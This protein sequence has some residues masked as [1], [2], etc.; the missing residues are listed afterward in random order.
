MRA[1]F[2]ECLEFGNGVL[3]VELLNRAQESHDS[4][5]E[6]QQPDDQP[7][8]LMMRAGEKEPSADDYTCEAAKGQSE[9]H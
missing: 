1:D 9:D 2:G 8:R 3:R 4:K 5:Y 7:C 6:Q